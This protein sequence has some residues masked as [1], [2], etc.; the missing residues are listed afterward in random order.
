MKRLLFV[1]LLTACALPACATN[2]AKPIDWTDLAVEAAP[3]FR[4]GEC[5]PELVW[6]RDIAIYDRV[7]VE[8]QLTV[9]PKCGDGKDRG[10][11]KEPALLKPEG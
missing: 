2:T 10:D 9:R 7:E 3:D 4:M 1:L 8:G 5:G 11:A 6:T